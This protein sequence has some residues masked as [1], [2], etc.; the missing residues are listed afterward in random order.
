MIIRLYGAFHEPP[1][2]GVLTEHLQIDSGRW[3]SE[4]A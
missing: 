1:P 2:L 3:R 4:V